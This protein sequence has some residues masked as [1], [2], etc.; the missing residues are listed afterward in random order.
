MKE[1]KVVYIAGPITG[2]VEYWKAFEDA[3]DKLEA[4]GYV[5][6]SP[7]RLPWNLGDDKAMPICLAMIN[8]ADAVC[9]LPGWGRSVGAQLEMAYCKY[10]DKPHFN[11]DELEEVEI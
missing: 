3:E 8:A 9:F 2:V 6:L 5:P 11:L 1:K 7:A 10:T 4:A